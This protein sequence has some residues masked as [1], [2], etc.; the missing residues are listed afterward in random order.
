M[1]KENRKIPKGYKMIREQDEIE[2]GHTS[3][4]QDDDGMGGTYLIGYMLIALTVLS[5]IGIVCYTVY[6]VI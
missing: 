1:L 2:R 5:A 6:Q 3:V 4:D